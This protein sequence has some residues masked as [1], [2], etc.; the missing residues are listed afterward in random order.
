MTI[1]VISHWPTWFVREKKKITKEERDS[2]SVFILFFFFLFWERSCF[3]FLAKSNKEMK[4]KQTQIS[5][6]REVRLPTNNKISK[7]VEG[8]WWSQLARHIFRRTN[9][10]TQL[11]GSLQRH[12]DN[13]V[14]GPFGRVTERHTQ[15]LRTIESLVTY[16]VIFF[17]KTILSLLL[18]I[19]PSCTALS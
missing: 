19:V 7:F 3:S 10:A 15:F 5:K 18:M 8:D 9:V 6:R 16:P 2:L 4:N 11:V 13:G 1:W 12:L 14:R 17:S